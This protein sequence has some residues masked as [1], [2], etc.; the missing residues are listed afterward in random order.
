MISPVQI[1]AHHT[2]V[3][4]GLSSPA[5]RQTLHNLVRTA[6]DDQRA[7]VVFEVNRNLLWHMAHC[8]RPEDRQAALDI[9]TGFEETLEPLGPY[10]GTN[11]MTA[12]AEALP[13]SIV[14]LWLNASEGAWAQN[15]F[16]NL[17][18]NWQETYFLLRKLN[19]PLPS[20]LEKL[21][22]IGLLS[23]DITAYSGP[24]SFLQIE[25]DLARFEQYYQTRG[26]RLIYDLLLRQ[27]DYDGSVVLH[28]ES[29]VPPYSYLLAPEDL[30]TFDHS[31]LALKCRN[32][33]ISFVNRGLE[34]DIVSFPDPGPANVFRSKSCPEEAVSASLFSIEEEGKYEDYL[35]CLFIKNGLPIGYGVSRP[36]KLFHNTRRIGLHIFKEFRGTDSSSKLFNGFLKIV[37]GYFHCSRFIIMR[38]LTGEPLRKSN[39]KPENEDANTRFYQAHGFRW[40]D[41]RQTVMVRDLS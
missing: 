29:R 32:R 30:L 7:K 24:E 26:P 41:D 17:T 33:S 3:L 6:Q 39:L 20:A 1:K 14:G 18:I 38:D 21:Q 13:Y 4:R 12:A 19:I 23:Q 28:G 22:A 11:F 31:R 8:P 25:Q 5:I 34:M 40:L 36:T 9:A 16:P 27:G 2:Q 10:F 15:I 35:F 37:Y